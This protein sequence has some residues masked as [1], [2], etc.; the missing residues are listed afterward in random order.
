ME[1]LQRWVKGKAYNV[2]FN[3]P[4]KA[5]FSLT[6]VIKVNAIYTDVTVRCSIFITPGRISDSLW[7]GLIDS[8]QI[9]Q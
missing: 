2:V 3:L 5:R 1:V 7:L 4:A 6:G 9:T 8:F